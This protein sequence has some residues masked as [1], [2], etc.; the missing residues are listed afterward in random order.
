MYFCGTTREAVSEVASGSPPYLPEILHWE[1]Y[2]S[3]EHAQIRTTR[4]RTQ[5]KTDEDVM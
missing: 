4:E 1:R 3:R 2:R 5:R